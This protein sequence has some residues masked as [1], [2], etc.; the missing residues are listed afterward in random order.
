M[1]TTA[2]NIALVLEQNAFGTIGDDIY[3]TAPRF[4]RSSIYITPTGGEP[5]QRL[6][7]G[8]TAM[9]H[10]AFAITIVKPTPEAVV[11]TTQNLMVL[12]TQ[13]VIPGVQYITL[14]SSSPVYQ[15]EGD[16]GQYYSAF[17]VVCKV[18]PDQF[19]VEYVIDGNIAD[20]EALFG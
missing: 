17:D 18:L 20:G 19:N 2:Q 13:A 4:A 12:L 7:G 8:A 10:L 11:N 14:S 1:P 3:I 16:D 5:P 9:W 15:G 6:I